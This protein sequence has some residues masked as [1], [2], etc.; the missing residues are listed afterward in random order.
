MGSGGERGVGKDR[1]GLELALRLI[2]VGRPLMLRDWGGREQTKGER[3]AGQAVMTV[4][5]QRV[6]GVTRMR[7]Q[8]Y[9]IIRNDRSWV[10][11]WWRTLCP[12]K[13]WPR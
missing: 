1:R 6:E 2:V 4:V 3:K 8:E 11:L 9:G 13:R 12:Q 5:G 7:E 10:R